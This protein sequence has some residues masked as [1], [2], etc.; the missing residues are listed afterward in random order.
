MVTLRR[1]FVCTT[2][3]YKVELNMTVPAVGSDTHRFDENIRLFNHFS[4]YFPFPRIIEIFMLV[5]SFPACGKQ[6]YSEANAITRTISNTLI[7]CLLIICE[8]SG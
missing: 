8:V 7:Q 1:E 4:D 5:R 2:F 3:L 6:S